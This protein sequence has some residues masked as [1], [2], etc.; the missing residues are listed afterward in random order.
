MTVPVASVAAAA[1]R[2][3]CVCVD[4]VRSSIKED[5]LSH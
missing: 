2:S 1:G 3:F 5:R 4:R